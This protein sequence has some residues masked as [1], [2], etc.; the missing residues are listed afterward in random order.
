MEGQ[1][2]S[3]VGCSHLARVS[4]LIITLRQSQQSEWSRF[5]S[6]ESIRGVE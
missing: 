5:E 1:A 4:R 6:S 3:Q 2:G